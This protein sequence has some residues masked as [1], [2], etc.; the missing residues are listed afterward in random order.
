MKNEAPVWEKVNLTLDEAASYFGIGVAK[1]KELT[2]P[3]DCSFVLWNGAKRLIK[4]R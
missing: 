1:L 2:S 4:R 3:P